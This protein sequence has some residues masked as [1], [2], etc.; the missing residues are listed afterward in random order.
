MEHAKSGNIPD[1]IQRIH[2]C[3][4][5]PLRVEILNIIAEHPIMTSLL[6]ARV[7]RSQS[8]LS[9][10]LIEMRGLNLITSRRIGR[11]GYHEITKRG[12]AMLSME[13]KLNPPKSTR[14]KKKG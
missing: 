14:A 13:T 8:T 5:N 9:E 1:E 7:G 2:H 12:R 3:L 4:S 6:M 11:M 10:I